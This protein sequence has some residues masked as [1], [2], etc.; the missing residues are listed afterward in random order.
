MND[1]AVRPDHAVEQNVTVDTENDRVVI[2]DVAVS[3]RDREG[4]KMALDHV[5]EADGYAAFAGTPDGD[6]IELTGEKASLEFEEVDD[7][8]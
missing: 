4:R 7:A 1:N 3:V 2:G 5:S 8:E 6:L